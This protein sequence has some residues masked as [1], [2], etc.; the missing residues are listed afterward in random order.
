[1]SSSI[2]DLEPVTRNLCQQLLAAWEEGMHP[3][4]RITQTLRTFDEQMHLYQQ[5]RRLDGK[6][7]LVAEPRLIVTKAQPGESPHNYGAA[8]D[9]CFTGSDPYLHAHEVANKNQPD[10]LWGLLGA[11]GEKLGLEWGGNWPTLKDRPHFQRPDWSRLR[12][13]HDWAKLA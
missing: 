5:G 9:V 6:V 8:F 1:M 11:V 13:A 12:I 3:P 4:L 2:Q 7:W 10:P